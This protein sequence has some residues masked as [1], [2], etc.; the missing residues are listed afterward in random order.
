MRLQHSSHG[1]RYPRCLW[2]NDALA[3]DLAIRSDEHV[4]CRS[5]GSDLAVVERDHTAVGLADQNEAATTEIAGF[6]IRNR[7]GEAGG[8][9]GVDR[10]SSSFEYFSARFGC[11]AAVA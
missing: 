6:R 2:T 9:G 8:D 11:E 10:V 3:C 5:H 4:A 1:A 7:Q